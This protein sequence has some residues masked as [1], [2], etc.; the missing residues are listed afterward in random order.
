[1]SSRRPD[2]LAVCVFCAASPAIDP[3]YVALAAQVGTAIADRGWGLVSGGGSVSSM[4]ALARAARAGGARTVGVIPRQLMNLEV[5]DHEA[6]ELV[7]TDGMRERKGVMDLRSDAFLTLPGGLGTLEE[8]LEVW[9]ART[10]G[11]HDKPVVV[12]DPD[13]VFAPLRAQVDALVEGGFVRPQARD[14]VVWADRIDPA[15]DAIAALVAR[16]MATSTTAVEAIEADP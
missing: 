15:L 6:D 16:P 7:V 3:A 4:G 1:M 2:G 10:L 12:L 9:V 11:L 13:D 14:A 8:L 5:S